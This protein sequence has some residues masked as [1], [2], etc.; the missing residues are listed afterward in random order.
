MNVNGTNLSMTRGDSETITISCAGR[1]FVEG[2]TVV[3]TVKKEVYDEKKVIQKT[4]T[5]F[6]ENG[7]A[8]VFIDPE[9]TKEKECGLYK[10]DVQL[11]T[12]SG[13]VVTIVKPG[14]FVLDWEV[15][16]D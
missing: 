9:D 10:Y 3:F 11:R 15:N 1:P 4:V 6:T 14:L 13:I 7:K 2:D 5:A 8:I 12:K 16:C